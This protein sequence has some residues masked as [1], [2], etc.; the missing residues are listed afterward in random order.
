MGNRKREKCRHCK[1]LFE[2]DPRNR[3]R[4]K[5]CYRPE[6]RKDSKRRS[7]KRWLKKPENRGYFSGPTNVERV[8]EWRRKHPGYW[9]KKKGALQETLNRQ[10]TVNTDKLKQNSSNAL[11]DSLS[12]QPPVFIGLISNIT[13]SA[14]QDDIARTILRLEQL[15]QDI[16]NPITQ[17]KGGFYDIETTYLNK[18]HP[19]GSQTVQLD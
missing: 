10:H 6:C 14:L 3:G 15:G 9:R 1:R 2:P 19:E 5:Y 4:Q 13:G 11:Q 16:L 18:P 17:T 12:L 7:Q 8:R